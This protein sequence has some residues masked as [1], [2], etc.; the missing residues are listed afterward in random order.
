MSKKPKARLLSKEMMVAAEIHRFNH[1]GEKVWFSKLAESLNGWAAP[2]TV[3]RA[4][5]TLTDWGI[6]K[7]Q[8]GATDTGKAGRL[9]L[10]AGEAE[11]TI[12]LVYEQYWKGRNK[13]K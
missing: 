4:I 5:T 13:N 12:S 10:I 8:Y 6:V 3:H 7:V 11:E 2:S 9:L 1:E